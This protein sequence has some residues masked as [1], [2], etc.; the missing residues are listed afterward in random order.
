MPVHFRSDFAHRR[1][2]NNPADLSSAP[3][4]TSTFVQNLRIFPTMRR[5]SMQI[6][7]GAAIRESAESCVARAFAGSLDCRFTVRAFRFL[8]I[9][10]FVVVY[11]TKKTLPQQKN[12]QQRIRP[13]LN[14]VFIGTWQHD[15]SET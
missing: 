4:P 12:D 8:Y 13:P 1:R 14:L 2:V 10:L 6:T 5:Q 11:K 9:A 3:C 15:W 7:R